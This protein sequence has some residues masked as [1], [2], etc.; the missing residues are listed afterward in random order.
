[1]EEA[2]ARAIW[3]AAVAQTE[4]GEWASAI[5]GFDQIYDDGATSEARKAKSRDDIGLCWSKIGTHD[6]A[7]GWF[8]E[9]LGMPGARADLRPE[10]LG[11]SG[12]RRRASRSTSRSGPSPTASRAPDCAVL[13]PALRTD[14]RTDGERRPRRR[15][16][17]SRSTAGSLVSMSA[18]ST[19]VV[20]ANR[21]DAGDAPASASAASTTDA[22]V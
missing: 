22:A 17:Q 19:R 11:R 16:T 7:M 2:E 13:G 14:H 9:W 10:V 21:A 3:D 6:G 8:G 18:G 1:M 15:S 5:Q 20:V 12:R 4:T